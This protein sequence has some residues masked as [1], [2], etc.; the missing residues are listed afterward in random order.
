[1]QRRT[2]V[3]YSWFRSEYCRCTFQDSLSYLGAVPMLVKAAWRN[4]VCFS[5]YLGVVLGLPVEE[6]NA[7][8]MVCPVSECA[9]LA[10][11]VQR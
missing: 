3:S 4:E 6:I 1:M 7:P 9:I 10:T 5:C 8:M 2:L 11:S